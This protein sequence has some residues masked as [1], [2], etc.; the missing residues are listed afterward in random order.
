M[1]NLEW[2]VIDKKTWGPGPWQDEPDKEQWV[3]KETG[4]PCLLVRNDAG[5]LCGYVG[6]AEGHPWHSRR[7]E[8]INP[9]PGVHREMSYSNLC[10][11][12]PEGE[13]VCHEAAPNEPDELWWVGFHCA[14]LWDLQPGYRATLETV[15]PTILHG[16]L[17]KGQTYRTAE[18]VKEQCTLLALAAR[19]AAALPPAS[20]TCPC[21]EAV[22]DR[23]QDIRSG[24]CARCH[25]WTG[26]TFL[27]LIHALDECPYRKDG[28]G[29]D[30]SSV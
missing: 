8:E 13:G 2:R 16:R 26:H 18:Y 25:A 28:Q 6:V 3:D 4:F 5:S 30:A 23:P 14:N 20:F 15:L 22:S 21:C 19:D 11:P 29:L 10:Q 12:A 24:Y 1:E 7:F 9:V 27:G 17:F